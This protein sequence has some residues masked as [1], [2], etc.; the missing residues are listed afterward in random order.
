MSNDA[1]FLDSST[2]RPKPHALSV[3]IGKLVIYLRGQSPRTLLLVFLGLP[4]S[5]WYGSHIYT[6][7]VNGPRTQDYED[8]SAQPE[9]I[10]SRPPHAQ[11]S[12]SATMT[13]A[14][15]N[16]SL[17]Q[18]LYVYEQAINA[19]LDD[20][21]KALLTIEA[22]R[23]RDEAEKEVRSS[24]E[25][26]ISEG[27]R[28][29][30]NVVDADE[31]DLSMGICIGV[32]DDELCVLLRY[33]GDALRHLDEAERDGNIYAFTAARNRMQASILAINDRQPLESIPVPT[34]SILWYRQDLLEVMAHA[35]R[36]RNGVVSEAAQRYMDPVG[37]G[38][39]SYSIDYSE[40]PTQTMIESNPTLDYR[41]LQ[42][43]N[44]RIPMDDLMG[45]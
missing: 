4:V 35:P 5:L 38:L 12:V 45:E 14:D 8:K 9:L 31:Y 3:L 15:V 13:T 20:T 17:A 11:L 39:D 40:S 42:T 28:V 16:A 33:L 10:L 37:S 27:K 2:P 26:P 24:K 6:Q 7:F 41:K 25:V 18:R 34:Q 21:A 36:F 32:T 29:V 19:T 1:D 44:Q 23:L 43:V 30:G 22:S